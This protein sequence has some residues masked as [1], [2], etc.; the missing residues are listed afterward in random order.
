MAF[1]APRQINIE[2]PEKLIEPLF[3]AKRYKGFYGGR[4]GGKSYAV[5]TYI[6]I[7]CLEKATRVLCVREIQASIKESVHQLLSERINEL[8]LQDRFE[9]LETEIR[10]TNGSEIVFKGMRSSNSSAVKSMQGI[11]I[12]WVEEAQTLSQKSLDDLRPTIRKAGSQQIYV[13]NPR[14][15]ADPVDA[16]F[17]GPAKNPDA[18]AVEIGW[19]D[20]PFLSSETVRDK[21]FDYIQ[22]PIKAQH[23]WGGGYEVL[24]EG[25][26][27]GRDIVAA[28]NEG[29]VGRVAYDREAAV[30][31]A[32][33]LGVGDA[34]SI[35]VFQRIALEWHVL[36]YYENSGQALSHYVDWINGL[37]YQV[38]QHYLPHDARQRELQTGKSRLEFF[39]ERGLR[40]SV[41]PNHTVD[42]GIHAVRMALPKMWIDEGHCERLLDCLRSYR[43]E[44]SDKLQTSKPQPLHD[45]AS[46]GADA[47]RYMV[48]GAAANNNNS[49]SDWS[50]PLSRAGS[51]IA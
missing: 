1:D 38:E 42:D 21:N 25:S 43:S 19:K 39:Q 7:R 2:L 50:R 45:W 26:Y 30:Y 11:D 24:T 16:F 29:R 23:V 14:F 9:I 8:G 28:E 47:L 48:M 10:G 34:T 40:T 51:G 22:D 31:A 27:Y 5:A 44:W 13:W 36:A 6:L 4:G 12:V 18:I 33:D 17:R 35:V 3:C 49:R 15:K 20:N 32:W 41:V 37:P 46:H